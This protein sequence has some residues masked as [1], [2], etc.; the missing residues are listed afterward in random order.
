MKASSMNCIES[1][2]DIIKAK[3]NKV[4]EFIDNL[5]AKQL[6]DYLN[7]VLTYSREKTG[8]KKILH[9]EI[10]AEIGRRIMMDSRQEM[11]MRSKEN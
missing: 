11:R 6:T 3:R 2:S 5:D 10:L 4:E 8:P 7:L 9:Q 1:I